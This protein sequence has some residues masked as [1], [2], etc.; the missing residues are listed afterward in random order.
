MSK[1]NNWFI[2]NLVIV[3]PIDF[4]YDDEYFTHPISFIDGHGSGW[5]CT[6]DTHISDNYYNL[7]ENYYEVGYLNGFG[8]GCGIGEFSGS[9][10]GFEE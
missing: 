8:Y 6:Y 1:L 4:I 2:N 7:P 9:S 3:D 5:G 10:N